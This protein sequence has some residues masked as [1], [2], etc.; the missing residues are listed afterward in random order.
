MRE[1]YLCKCGAKCT[2][3]TDITPPA[4]VKCFKCKEKIHRK[5]S[6]STDETPAPEQG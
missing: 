4:H 6:Q 3:E 2:Y 5:V 1:V